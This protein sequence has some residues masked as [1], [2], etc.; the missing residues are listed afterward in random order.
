MKIFEWIKKQSSPEAKLLRLQKEVS[1][2]QRDAKF[3]AAELPLLLEKDKALEVINK[4]R[5]M[6]KEIRRKQLERLNP[7]GKKTF[8]NG[9]NLPKLKDPGSQ[10]R[11]KTP[12]DRVYKS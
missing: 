8:G 1:R 7:E 3:A 11:I 10:V 2:K 9:F 5:D 12:L 4:R 6:K